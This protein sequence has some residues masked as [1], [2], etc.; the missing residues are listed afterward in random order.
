MERGLK[1]FA[2]PGR[3]CLSPVKQIGPVTMNERREGETIAPRTGEIV[4]AHTG[5]ARGG[6]T[7]PAQQRLAS[8]Q[9]LLADDNVGD[10]TCGKE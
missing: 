9:V 3:S 5:I 2:R 8:G 10:L 6:T 1:P 4:N 7:R